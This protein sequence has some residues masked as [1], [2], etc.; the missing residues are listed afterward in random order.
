[1]SFKP[2][3]V[4]VIGVGDI[5]DVYLNMISR[6]PALELHTLAGRRIERAQVA[7]EKYDA[8]AATVE[9]LV[10][11]DEIE[12][13]VNLAPAS[14]HERLNELVVSSGKHLY[15]EKPFALSKAAALSLTETAERH[16]VLIGTAPD[17]FY[18]GSHQAVR[19]AFDDGKIGRAVFGVSMIGLPG[20]EYFHPNPAAFYQPGGEV[21]LDI[22]PYYI[23]QWINLL[24]PVRRVY[25]SSGA[26]SAERTIRRGELAGTTFPV[27][28][29]TTFSIILEFEQGSVNIVMSLDAAR[30]VSRPGEIYGSQGILA[31]CEPIF[32][33]GEPKLF[34]AEAG[35]VELPSDGFAFSV[36]NRQNHFG[37]PVADYRGVGLVDLALAVRSGTRHRTGPEWIVHLSDV[38]ES[39]VCSAREHKAITLAT[40]CERPAPIDKDADA[41]LVAMTPSPFDLIG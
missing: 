29:P 27:T 15:S 33:S 36:P 41:Q 12:V 6:S 14:Q 17:T 2:L 1:M 34:R 24:G 20:L 37:T 30:P 19:K 21:P 7:A 8:R 40:T 23:A 9:Q 39:I 5:S 10:G 18:G 31:L 22:G 16:D 28:V 4:G 35:E 11:N 25:A 32:F 38:M 26:G 13:V 3:K